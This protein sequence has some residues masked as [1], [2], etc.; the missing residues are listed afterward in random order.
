MTEPE[1]FSVAR[2]AKR[3]LACPAVQESFPKWMSQAE[4]EH[5]AYEAAQ[6]LHDHGVKAERVVKS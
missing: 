2:L 4:K 6:W 5:R 1:R 3:I